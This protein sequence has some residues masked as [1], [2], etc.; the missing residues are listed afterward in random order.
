MVW[1]NI[2]VVWCNYKM[3]CSSILVVW[4]NYIIRDVFDTFPKMVWGTSVEE[5]VNVLPDFAQFLCQ[6]CNRLLRQELTRFITSSYRKH[7]DWGLAGLA[8]LSR[9]S[10]VHDE[11]WVCSVYMSWEG[12]LGVLTCP[13]IS[14]LGLLLQYD[15]YTWSSVAIL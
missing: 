12:R 9:Q 13:V 15:K 11:D 7:E 8:G 2:V 6:S 5:L 10:S 1:G 3:V 14:T 4:G